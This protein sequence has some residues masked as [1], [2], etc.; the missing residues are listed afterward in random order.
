MDKRVF[1]SLDTN[2]WRR[3]SK[4]DKNQLT[5]KARAKVEMLES[6][7]DAEPISNKLKKS[8]RGDLLRTVFSQS[9]N[10]MR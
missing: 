8:L 3:N 9:K 2:D 1:Q 6:E 10:I 7:I 4:F 5:R